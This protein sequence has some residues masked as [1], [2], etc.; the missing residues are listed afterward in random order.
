MSDKPKSLSNYI[1]G[2]VLHE[3]DATP[4]LLMSIRDW[5]DCALKEVQTDGSRRNAP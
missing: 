3:E 1:G 2:D 4:K 5:A